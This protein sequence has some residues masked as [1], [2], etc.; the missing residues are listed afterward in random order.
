MPNFIK[1]RRFFRVFLQFQRLYKRR[2]LFARPVAAAFWLQRCLI[3]LLAV[4][5]LNLARRKDTSNTAK[6]RI[7]GIFVNSPLPINY[8]GIG[9]KY[10]LSIFNEYIDNCEELVCCINLTNMYILS[11]KN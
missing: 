6:I 8:L 10:Q 11:V 7:I 4:A 9:W 2:A 5:K 1:K 3:N